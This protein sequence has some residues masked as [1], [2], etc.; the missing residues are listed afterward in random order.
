M[1]RLIALDHRFEPRVLA[2]RVKNSMASNGIQT[3]RRRL[4]ATETHD[5]SFAQM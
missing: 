2:A 1:A 3:P 5:I 4:K